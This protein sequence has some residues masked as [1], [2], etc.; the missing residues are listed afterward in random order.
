MSLAEAN[1]RDKSSATSRLLPD[2]RF[3]LFHCGNSVTNLTEL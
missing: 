2:N 3:S 1:G